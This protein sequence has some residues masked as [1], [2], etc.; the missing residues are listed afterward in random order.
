MTDET[1]N[2]W[3]NWATWSVT[4]AFDNS[5]KLHVEQQA[6]LASFDPDDPPSGKDVETFVR[7]RFI[8]VSYHTE[9]TAKDLGDVN[10]DELA[11]SWFEVE[12][13]EPPAEK[14]KFTPPEPEWVPCGVCG[15]PVPA[16]RVVRRC[17]AC[18]E[19]GRASTC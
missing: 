6:F 11:E 4:A 1:Y 15:V 8:L 14:P 16:G 7:E 3:T 9:M 13:E 2:N 19:K 17:N 10:W 18:I 12:E 5:E